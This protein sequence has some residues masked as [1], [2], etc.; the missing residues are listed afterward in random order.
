MKHKPVD[1]TYN[2]DDYRIDITYSTDEAKVI[3]DAYYRTL[4]MIEDEINNEDNKEIK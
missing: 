4:D 3:R 2:A 1:D